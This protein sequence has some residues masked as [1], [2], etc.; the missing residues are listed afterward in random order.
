MKAK[1]QVGTFVCSMFAG[2]SED[3]LKL[4][5]SFRNVAFYKLGS[6]EFQAKLRGINK[7]AARSKENLKFFKEKLENFHASMRDSLY[8][9]LP[10]DLSV[11]NRI[12]D[13]A[14]IRTSLLI[15]FPADF[16]DIATIVFGRGIDGHFMRHYT[17]SSTYK[18]NDLRKGKAKRINFGA[19]NPEDASNFIRNFID[20]GNTHRYLSIAIQSYYNSFFQDEMRLCYTTLFIALESGDGGN[21]RN[22]S[23]DE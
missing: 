13:I 21:Y 6:P 12:H 10:I 14:E 16:R 17:A 19:T 22:N 7:R 3:L 11:P 5:L 1:K 23:S 8:V 18:M 20:K 9:L 4:D 15:M 2:G